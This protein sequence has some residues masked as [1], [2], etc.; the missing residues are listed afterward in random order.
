[1]ALISMVSMAEMG[2]VLT[3]G[4]TSRMAATSLTPTQGRRNVIA[5]NLRRT[6]VDASVAT[7]SDTDCTIGSE[8]ILLIESIEIIP[9]DGIHYAPWSG[10]SF[11][12]HGNPYGRLNASLDRLGL[13]QFAFATDL[14]SH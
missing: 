1:M 14:R 12:F 11:D 10:V 6:F 5:G 7:K 2:R 4:R 9:T 3:T 8:L 13:H